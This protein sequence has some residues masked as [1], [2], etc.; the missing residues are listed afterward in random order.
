MHTAVNFLVRPQDDYTD[1]SML[2]FVQDLRIFAQGME[3][4]FGAGPA[5]TYNLHVA[6]CRLPD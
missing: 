6:V 4:T 3:L 1:E 5:T 2:A